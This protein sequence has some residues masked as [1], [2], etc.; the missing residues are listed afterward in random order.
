ML[1]LKLIHVNKKIPWFRRNP[2]F[3]GTKN[4]MLNHM[5]YRQFLKHTKNKTWNTVCIF[6]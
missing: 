4:V 5:D 6:I 2:I 3:A 1:E